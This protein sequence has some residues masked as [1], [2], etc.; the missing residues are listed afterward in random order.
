MRRL[1]TAQLLAFLL[2]LG[3][4]ALP[5]VAWAQ[6]GKLSGT[7][8]E[9]GTTNPVPGATVVLENTTFATA[10]DSE[11]RYVIIGIT[12]GVF[13]VRF[14]S[15]GFTP[16]AIE[17][18]RVTSDRTTTLNANL[19][20]EVVQGNE[21][22]VEAE[23]PVVDQNQTTSRALITQ[24]EI[25]R[26]PVTSLQDVISRTANSY[27]G[28]IRG[29]RRIET[30]TVIEGIDVTDAFYALAPNLS[31]GGG[32]FTG[33]TY[34]N[35]NKADE[36]NTSMFTLSPEAVSEVTV[37]TGATDARYATASGGVVAI[38]MEEGRG[39]LSGSFSARVSPQINIPGPDSLAFYPTAEVAT[40][41]AVRDQLTEEG[42]KEAALFT[43]TPDKY[44]IG[45]KPEM[46]MRFSLGG[47]L[48][49]KW[50]FMTSGQ[51][52]QTNGFEP[53]YFDKRVGGTLK[54]S[55]NLSKNTRLTAFGI[56]EDRGLWGGW[57]NRNYHDYW[58]YYLEGV[59]QDDGGSYLGS[60]QWTQVLSP[61]S[62]FS[63]QAYR[64]FTRTRY[65][66]VDDNANGFTDPGEDGDFLDFKDPAV[67]STYIGDAQEGKMF[68]K[69]ISN[70]YPVIGNLATD[71]WKMR[72]G[73]PVPYSEDASN[74]TN[75][76]RLDYSNQITFNHFLQA[77]AEFKARQFDYE[78]VYGIDVSWLNET[79]EPY[80]YQNW[81]RHPW[82]FSLY[83]SDRMEYRGLIVNLGLRADV[84][85]RDT[86][87]LA[88]YFS[89]FQRDTVVVA[90]REL[91]RN[92]FQRGDRVP[93]EVYLNPRIGV[94]HPIGSRAAMYFSYAR[95]VQL[96]YATLYTFYDGNNSRSSFFNYQDPAQ[97][98][99]KSNNY[100]LGLQWEF[101][102]GWGA[103]VNAYMRA[104]EN[105]GQILLEATGRVPAGETI[106]P[107]TPSDVYRYATSFGY[108]DA[109][110][111]E[112][113]LRR[114]PLQ[115]APDVT[116]GLTAS[117]TYSTVEQAANA[118][119]SL[120]FA[121]PDGTVKQ[122]P[123]DAA[124]DAINFPIAVVGG[125]STLAQGYDR[126][127]RGVLRAVSALP[128]NFSLG[129][130]GT[131]ESGFLYQKIINVDARDRKLLTGPT[132]Y[133]IDLRAEKRFN[134]SDRLGADLYVDV[135]NLTNR[136]NVIAYNRNEFSGEG[137]TFQETGNPGSRLVQPDGSTLYGPARNIYFGA[138]V[139]F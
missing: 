131:L 46:D 32:S 100:E 53:N 51:W 8:T 109:R 1:G 92:V 95:N 30:K 56:V 75:G 38:V 64:T 44:Q 96:I 69:N 10:T 81:T 106:A 104:I 29:S 134:F 9:T 36:V 28:F 124:K 43:W 73:Q 39:P 6:T 133:Q 63:L 130:T 20:I 79:D 31:Y 103:D 135:I 138:R 24:E 40:Y 49:D 48:T 66:Y 126:R 47:S 33:S 71:T 5:G 129:L 120:G 61:T 13:T 27:E 94:S 98:P 137:R 57:N 113:V 88:D 136:L 132:N 37:N 19:A 15:V 14:S 70:T 119:G 139:R 105:Y 17:D 25:S 125:R 59:A 54:T 11:G 116:L 16:K 91:A 111:V 121:D 34:N 12:P 68:S 99:I 110:G 72:A 112:L 65:G 3:L 60:L 4:Q 77:G 97:K 82:E 101:A 26:L 90:G 89:P 76:L 107:G 18:V 93:M 118:A 67:I 41:N 80:K 84:I 83:G 7:V 114:R 45:H 42:K 74:T 62:F 85:N 86:R 23:R 115:L 122:L 108:A 2:F 78:E 52:F 21:V 128:L 50:T 102:P 55:Y 35:T 58:R 22:V 117:Y 123:F 127:H 87:K